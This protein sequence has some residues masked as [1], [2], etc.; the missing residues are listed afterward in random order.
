MGHITAQLLER[1]ASSSE[2]DPSVFPQLADIIAMNCMT[3]FLP[4]DPSLR[5]ERLTK[6]QLAEVREALIQYIESSQL[7]Q[8]TGSAFLCLS[9]FFDPELK[10]YFIDHLSL[11]YQQARDSLSAMGHIEICLDNLDEDILSDNSFGCA[12]HEKNM[13]D[14]WNYLKR[15]GKIK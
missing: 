6:D 5:S 14:A 10:S 8:G 1:L 2:E 12:D 13:K 15:L 4:E 3:G 7:R 11:Y 9:K